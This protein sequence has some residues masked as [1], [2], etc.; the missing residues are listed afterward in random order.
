MQ[1]DKV[2]AESAA[3]WDAHLHVFDTRPVRGH[4]QPPVCTLDQWA[5]AAHPLG[6]RHAVLVQPSVYGSDNSLLL[7]AL[8]A[9]GGL[10]RGVVVL[11]G[12]EDEATLAAMHAAGVRGLRVNAVSPVGNAAQ[13]SAALERLAPLLRELGWHLQCYARPDQL[14]ALAALARRLGL[15]LVLDHLAGFTPALWREAALR[16]ALARLAAQG[17]WVKLSAWYRLDAPAPYDALQEAI[18][19]VHALFES[20]CVWGSDWPHTRFMEP[21]V[22]GPA[23]TLGELIAPVRHVLG[24][25]GW[26]ALQ[27]A[28][29]RLYA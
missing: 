11:A 26:A 23:P 14:T 16:E 4:Y 9:S 10:H 21:G 22:P 25:P 19:G 27:A 5:A 12:D 24:E 13:A 20:R 28:A 8:R 1:Q 7:E 29:A 18:A 17:A 15:P 6:L 2:A 3:G